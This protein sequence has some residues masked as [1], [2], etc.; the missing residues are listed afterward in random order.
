MATDIAQFFVALKK[1]PG[2]YSDE[3]ALQKICLACK[4]ENLPHPTYLW[5]PAPQEKDDSRI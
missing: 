1:E 5:E 2:L 3:V 4:T